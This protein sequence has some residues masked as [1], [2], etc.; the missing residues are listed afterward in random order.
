MASLQPATLMGYAKVWQKS[1]QKSLHTNYIH[2]LVE[3]FACVLYASL[4]FQWL[5]LP[6]AQSAKHADHS[7]FSPLTYK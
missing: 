4:C 2:A 1:L 7:R 3:P 6:V 5:M